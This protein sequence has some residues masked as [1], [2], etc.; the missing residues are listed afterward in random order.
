MATITQILSDAA[1]AWGI[2][3]E[4]FYAQAQKESSLN[5]N[6]YNAASGAA[7]LLQLEPATAR[8]LGVS[9]VMDPTQNANAGAQYLAQLYN[10][11]GDW[12]MALAAYDWGPDNVSKAVNLY[13]GDWLSHAPAETQNYVATILG[14]SGMDYTASVTPSSVIAGAYQ[15]A[16]S[17]V[18]SAAPGTAQKILLL[19]GAALG[20]YLLAVDL[21]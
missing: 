2:P 21:L 15:T 3:F 14:N 20:V 10:Q 8:Q 1:A 12:G 11:F 7:G 16:V 13:D 4:L 19:T 6:A 5:P 9:N 17:A 18:N